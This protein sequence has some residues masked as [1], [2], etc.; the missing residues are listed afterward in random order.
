M[1]S[2]QYQLSPPEAR[3]TGSVRPRRTNRIEE[4]Q[5][6]IER[7]KPKLRIAV[8][9]GGD[10]NDEGAVI[11]T[12]I[13]PRSWKSYETVARDIAAALGRLGFEHVEVMPEGGNRRFG[14][15]ATGLLAGP[16]PHP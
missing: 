1:S 6:Q 5:N 16:S 15:A 10:K 8:I 11:N 14:P 9:Y 2:L 13:T 12:T 4:L 7:L 3:S